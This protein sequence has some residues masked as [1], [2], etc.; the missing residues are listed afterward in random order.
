VVWRP[1]R[2][3]TLVKGQSV[4]LAAAGYTEAGD[5]VAA[6]WTSKKTRVASVT[7][8]GRITAKRAGSAT[9]V[10]KAGGKST[11]VIVRVVAKKPTAAK[12]KVTTV[13]AEG[14]PARMAV[15]K[16]ALIKGAYFPTTAVKAKVSFTSST[17]SVVSV[18]SRGALRALAPGSATITVKAS[19][20]TKKYV[21]RVHS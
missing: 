3:I 14:V 19:G 13:A 4:R 17:P 20:V 1:Q 10:A 12:A 9:L 6:S 16:L 2:Q 21:V 7:A 5:V 15:G 18:D 11:T 8:Q